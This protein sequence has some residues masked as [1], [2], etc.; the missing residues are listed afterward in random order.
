M[1]LS[2]SSLAMAG[3]IA[4][5]SISGGTLYTSG[6]DQLYGW[7]FSTNAAVT[8]TALGVY[9]SHEPGLNISHDVG[10]YRQS[11]QSLLGSTTVAAGV[12]GFLD[13]GFRFTNLSTSVTLSPDTYVIVMTMPFGNVDSQLLQVSSFN[14]ASQITWI[15]STVA[16]SSALA[17]PIPGGTGQYAPGAFGPNFIIAEDSVPEPGSALLLLA[18]M[19]GLLMHRHFARRT[20]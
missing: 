11:D 7:I 4:I 13:S 17:F 3:T 2:A 8:V 1:L 5:S 16:G 12:S 9:D 14:T 18:G 10:I 20:L 19:A 15:N 6:S